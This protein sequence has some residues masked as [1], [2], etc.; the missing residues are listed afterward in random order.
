[1]F[2]RKAAREMDA[3]VLDSLKTKGMT[4]TEVAPQERARM[5]DRLKTVT[6]KYVKESGE[7]LA[8]EMFA[9][10]DKVRAGK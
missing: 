8:R 6:E 2:Q 1:M 5:R 7:P 4:I 9:E 10:L 3:K